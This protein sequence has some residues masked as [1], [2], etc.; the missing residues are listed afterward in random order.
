MTDDFDQ[1]G[2]AVLPPTP[3]QLE[4]AEILG[5]VN[6]HTMTRAELSDALDEA[7]WDLRTG[8]FDNWEPY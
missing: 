4:Y 3:A 5:I 6:A 7:S 8:D 1:P 2:V